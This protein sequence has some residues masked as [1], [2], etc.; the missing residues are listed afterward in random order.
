MQ[1]KVD[2]DWQNA[3]TAALLRGKSRMAEMDKAE[4]EVKERRQE[5]I[6]EAWEAYN[7]MVRA[8]LPEV[9]R[10]M[11]SSLN[12]TDEAPSMWAYE[13]VMIDGE[14]WGLAPIAVTLDLL[15]DQY[16]VKQYEVYGI[17]IMTDAAGQRVAMFEAGDESFELW[18]AI[19]TDLELALARAYQ[20]NARMLDI[21]FGLALEATQEL[22]YVPAEPVGCFPGGLVAEKCLVS[23]IRAIVT[24]QMYKPPSAD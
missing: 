7:D 11:M 8:A 12:Y 22:E 17:C 23:A 24:D 16:S 6:R 13:V 2:S 14:A 19:E 4:A 21:K 5:E 18:P 3:L 10:P 1:S 20:H 9:L 15:N